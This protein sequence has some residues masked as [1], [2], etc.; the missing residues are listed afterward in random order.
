MV[1]LTLGNMGVDC[2]LL[3]TGRICDISPSA[4]WTLRGVKISMTPC[5]SANCQAATW[6]WECTLLTSPTSC[7]LA[8]PWTPKQ[9]PGQLNLY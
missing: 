3:G 5:T 7:T 2:M 6:S 9:P 4:A 8:Q 1:D